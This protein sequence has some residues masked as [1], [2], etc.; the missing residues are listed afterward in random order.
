MD[1][2]HGKRATSRKIEEASRGLMKEKELADKYVK[3]LEFDLAQ[4]IE[5]ENKLRADVEFYRGKC[6]RLELALN[7]T[8]SPA[9][10]NYVERSEPKKPPIGQTRIEGMRPPF[11]ELRRRWL[12]L[13][14]QE[15]ETAHKDG[16]TVENDKIES[17]VGK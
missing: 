16:W 13:S 9:Q 7:Q 4:G 12:A 6:E 10:Q 17:E 2:E 5:R 11:S 14:E 3:L 8:G 1:Q 15:Q